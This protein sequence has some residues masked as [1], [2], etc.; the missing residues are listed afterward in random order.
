M[1]ESKILISSTE[2]GTVFDGFGG[3][4]STLVACENTEHRCLMMEREPEYCEV[5]IRRW[6]QLT[7]SKAVRVIAHTHA[8][9][10]LVAVC[11]LQY[12]LRYLL[13]LLHVDIY[14]PFW[15]LYYSAPQRIH[16]ALSLQYQGCPAL[17]YS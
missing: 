8:I 1:L 14:L 10:C 12:Y 15:L 3:S 2:D 7:G 9:A 6:E 13:D 17:F 4:G 5:I 11:Q 16:I